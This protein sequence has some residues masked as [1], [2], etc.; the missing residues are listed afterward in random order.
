MFA[1]G[2]INQ[3]RV[4]G[5]I[6]ENGNPAIDNDRKHSHSPLELARPVSN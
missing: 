5:E 6:D 2:S 4:S 3:L 1:S